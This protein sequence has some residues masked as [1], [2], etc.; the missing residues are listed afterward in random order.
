MPLLFIYVIFLISFFG[1]SLV[2]YRLIPPHDTLITEAS[3]YLLFFYAI[4]LKTRFRT[5]RFSCHLWYPYTFFLIVT[6]SSMVINNYFSLEPVYSLRLILRFYVF[7]LAL[8]N[9]GLDDSNLKKINKLLFLLFIIQI[10]A[11]AYKFSYRGISD[12]T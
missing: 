11:V 4:A 2:D 9:L 7:Y 10:A 12:R 8:I 1:N 6:F 3:V 5:E